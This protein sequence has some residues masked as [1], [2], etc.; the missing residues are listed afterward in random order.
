M[1]YTV[2]T[3]TARVAVARRELRDALAEIDRKLKAQLLV[4][5]A[6]HHV[7]EGDYVALAKL[8]RDDDE[9]RNLVVEH[10][11]HEVLCEA[12]IAQGHIP[13]LGDDGEVG[14]RRPEDVPKGNG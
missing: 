4:L 5:A 2:T 6:A 7:S 13:T 14:W 10:L 3:E 11:C 1:P 8:G 9:V 12:H